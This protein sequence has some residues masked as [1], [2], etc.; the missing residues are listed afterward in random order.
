VLPRRASAERE[1]RI[2]LLFAATDFYVWKLF[3]K[4]LAI[5]REATL[6]RMIDLAVAASRGD[7][8]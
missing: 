5:G 6:E 8:Q 1:R 3:R 4:D 7:K 2:L